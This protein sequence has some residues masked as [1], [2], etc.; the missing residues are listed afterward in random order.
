[1][2]AMEEEQ[3]GRCDKDTCDEEG[4]S[5]SMEEVGRIF[6]SGQEEIKEESKRT[7][8]QK[9]EGQF[10]RLVMTSTGKLKYISVAS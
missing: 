1:M 5:K 7:N 6:K 4:R 2:P 9:M 10:L 8:P 3:K